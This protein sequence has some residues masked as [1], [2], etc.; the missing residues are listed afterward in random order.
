MGFLN[1]S[2]SVILSVVTLFLITYVNYS[3]LIM[4]SCSLNKQETEHC[5]N[6]SSDSHSHS[7]TFGAQLITSTGDVKLLQQQERKFPSM[8]RFLHPNEH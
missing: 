5:K 1:I 2:R 7:I 6:F 8:Y 3:Y 4:N